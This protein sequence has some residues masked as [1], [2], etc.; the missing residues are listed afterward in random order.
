MLAKI[1]RICP[2]IVLPDTQGTLRRAIVVGVT[3]S[4]D[5]CLEASIVGRMSNMYFDHK[6]NP[7]L[8]YAYPDTKK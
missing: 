2:G 7:Y 4:T 3:S 6:Y 8:E 5:A 1:D